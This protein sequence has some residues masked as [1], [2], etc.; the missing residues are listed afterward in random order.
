MIPEDLEIFLYFNLPSAVL[1]KIVFVPLSQY[2]HKGV[3]CGES[4]FISVAKNSIFLSSSSFA[5][6]SVIVFD[7]DLCNNKGKPIYN[8]GFRFL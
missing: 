7:Y 1:V 4:S 6:G 3:V 8:L 5:T 2:T